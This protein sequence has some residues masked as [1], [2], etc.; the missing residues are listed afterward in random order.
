MMPDQ[1]DA[2]RGLIRET[3]AFAIEVEAAT[4]R[5][6]DVM[7]FTSLPDGSEDD[8]SVRVRWFSVS[9]AGT[10]RERQPDEQVAA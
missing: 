2:L 8:E 3:S 9:I 4:Y 1:V 6:V 5:S 10:I 7:T